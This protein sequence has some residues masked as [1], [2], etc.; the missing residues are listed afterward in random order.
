VSITTIGRT[1]KQIETLFSDIKATQQ[2]EG[3]LEVFYCDEWGNWNLMGTKPPRLFSS[4]FIPKKQKEE[5]VG[6]AKWYE[7]NEDWY[8][9]RGIPYRLG[10]LLYGPPGTGKTSAA[11]ALA[12][13][14]KK[15]VF[16][17]NP[18]S[19]NT[20][21]SLYLSLSRVPKG[22]VILMEDVDIA[23]LGKDRKKTE[24]NKVEANR[25]ISLS[26]L[27]NSLDGVLAAEDRIL[28]MTT[29]NIDSL[30]PALIRPGRI[31]KKLEIGL[32]D[33]AE[34]SEMAATFAPD[35]KALADKI[36]QMAQE[37]SPRSGAYWQ[38]QLMEAINDRKVLEAKA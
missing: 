34:V 22:S 9:E 30:D 1:K 37:G 3:R 21:G 29:N 19:L 16:V 4:I 25:S 10:Y 36:V 14:L 33:V 38:Q 26:C 6:L 31:D 12:S 17:I 2:K 8:R 20:E 13:E 24:G 15:R 23:S 32:M 7:A 5:M 35:D 27:L 28:I 11:M 18:T